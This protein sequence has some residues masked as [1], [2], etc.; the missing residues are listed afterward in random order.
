MDGS[1][2][3]WRTSPHFLNRGPHLD[4]FRHL[5]FS[6]FVSGIHM[7]LVTSPPAGSIRYV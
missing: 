4:R 2:A 1:R 7:A 3:G 6:E 5:V